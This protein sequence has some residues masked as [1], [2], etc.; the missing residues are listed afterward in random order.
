MQIYSELKSTLFA[1]E[2]NASKI[3]VDVMGR[4][5][6]ES[7]IDLTPARLLYLMRKIQSHQTTL[8]WGS[9]TGKNIFEIMK[10]SF[11]LW[12]LEIWVIK[13]AAVVIASAKKKKYK[14]DFTAKWFFNSI[15]AHFGKKFYRKITYTVVF[16]DLFIG[17]KKFLTTFEFHDKY[18]FV[19]HLSMA[20]PVW[21][22]S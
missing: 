4:G 14:L 15:T 7:Q 12:D 20:A 19:Y 22:T 18:F 10:L 11:F 9:A 16:M 13:V 3:W 5:G 6:G 17:L 21:F 8:P 1:T 2:Q